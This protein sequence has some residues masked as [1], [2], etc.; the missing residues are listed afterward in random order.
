MEQILTDTTAGYETLAAVDWAFG[1][2]REMNVLEGVHPYPAK[3]IGQIPR[4]LIRELAPPPGTAILDPF[5]GSGTTL[6]EAQRMG[7]E[8]V[9]VDLNPIACL[10]SRVKTA[11]RPDRLVES[12]F[13]AIRLAKSF[14]EAEVP[15]LP[16]LS[17]WFHEEVQDA[18]ARLTAAIPLMPVGT[19]DAL[20]LALSRIVV[21]VSRQ[22]SD[23][24]YAAIENDIRWDDVM[25][26]FSTA[27]ASIDNAL[28][29]RGWC[30]RSC[31]VVEADIL[32]VDAGQLGTQ[33]VGLVITSPPY[34]NA[35][36]YWLYHKYR[37]LWLGFD[38]NEVKRREIGARAHFFKKNR[39]TAQDFERQMRLTMSLLDRV[40]EPG[41]H[42]CVVVGRSK[43]HGE[44]VDN[45]GTV[46][47]IAREMGYRLV[48]EEVRPINPSRKSFN[49][50]HANIRSE[51]VLA[52]RKPE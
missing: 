35:Y 3:F 11:S 47:G 38:A 14:V 43:I 46:C 25:A 19:R 15:A 12:G 2:E 33:P 13:D 31:K 29:A 7:Y 17:H 32:T 44:I 49:L 45:A 16:N 8:S 24:R 20:S 27:V 6:V 41:G 50:S 52:F 34:P 30:L 28:A 51:S 9:G 48:L 5:C 39:H 22:E 42:V 4:T 21:R 18:L 37:M 26:A 1:A 23:T 36:E 10:M 40:L